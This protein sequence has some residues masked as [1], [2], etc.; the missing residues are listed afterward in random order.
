M[1][2]ARHRQIGPSTG[3]LL[4]ASQR[5]RPIHSVGA[6]ITRYVQKPCMAYRSARVLHKSLGN[7]Q[8][9]LPGRAENLPQQHRVFGVR[10]L[11][12]PGLSVTALMIA[13]GATVC[14]HTFCK[15]HCMQLS[16]STVLN[17]LCSRFC[18][19]SCVHQSSG[20]DFVVHVLG[21]RA[22]RTQICYLAVL[23]SCCVL[24]VTTRMQHGPQDTA[25]NRGT[26][27]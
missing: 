16:F 25:L 19:T 18:Q 17:C 7:W 13:D 27:F 23:A 9:C 11:L 24:S 26:K 10:S 2:Q 4:T 22:A 6:G 8:E 20:S 21:T 15:S 14:L 5:K 12:S 1:E 3:R